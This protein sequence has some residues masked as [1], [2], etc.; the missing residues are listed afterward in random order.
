MVSVVSTHIL[1]CLVA[2]V[3]IHILCCVV[4]VVST[5]SVHILY[6]ED[7][8]QSIVSAVHYSL[9]YAASGVLLTL[10][11]SWPHVTDWATWSK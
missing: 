7:A 6:C 5:G 8:I 9:R 4:S 11:E 3:S 10:F 1:Y 2:I